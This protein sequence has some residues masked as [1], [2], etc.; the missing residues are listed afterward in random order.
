MRELGQ[1]DWC[2]RH[3]LLIWNQ[4]HPLFETAA[5]LSDLLSMNKLCGIAFITSAT[6]T[7]TMAE[8]PVLVP[9][10]SVFSKADNNNNNSNRLLQ[11]V[12]NGNDDG[13]GY[14]V[15]IR[16]SAT[17]RRKL[18]AKRGV[19]EGDSNSFVWA[20]DRSQGTATSPVA[21]TSP[22]GTTPA[23]C[24]GQHQLHDSSADAGAGGFKWITDYLEEQE[25]P[26]GV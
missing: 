4:D 6:P 20:S 24:S 17:T 1:A 11:L 9:Q 10:S 12:W 2:L 15:I 25:E 5:G 8:Q 7:S 14:S 19:V 22:L 16:M 23:A 21:L 13:D 26:Q 3:F 18:H